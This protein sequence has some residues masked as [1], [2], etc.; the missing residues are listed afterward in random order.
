MVKMVELHREIQLLKEEINGAIN[1][2]IE[3]AQF[4][5]GPV[6]KE[7]EEKLRDFLGVTHAITLASGS[8]A[9][10]LALKA[11]HLDCNSEVITT[12]FSFIATAE[13]IIR[14]GAKPVFADVDYNTMNID[15]KS[16]EKNINNKTRAI[17]VVHIFGNPCKLDEIAEIARKY[18][19]YL[20]EDCAQSFGSTFND[21]F[22]GTFGDCG[23][24]SFFPTK[25]LAVMAMVVLLSQ[26]VM[27]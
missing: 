16:I 3:S 1:S 18:H 12:A 4:I 15:P 9:L 13:A 17:V 2:V 27:S 22:V 11:V 20:I 10:F 14:A 26:I 19:L 5:E 21:Q 24:F 7:L 6:V 8:D 23:C 25:N